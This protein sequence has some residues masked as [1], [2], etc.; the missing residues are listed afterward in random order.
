MVHPRI[1]GT[2]PLEMPVVG[3]FDLEFERKAF[4]C[5]RSSHAVPKVAVPRRN[6]IRLPLCALWA[7]MSTFRTIDG[8]VA[9]IRSESRFGNSP[10]NFSRR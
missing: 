7:G 6:V 3:L 1:H 5:R 10:I 2:V 8:G 4:S 9:Q